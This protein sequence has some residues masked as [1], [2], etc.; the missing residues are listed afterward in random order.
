[1][2]LHYLQHVP[3]EGLGCIA[4]WARDAHLTVTHTR[5]F[6]GESLPQPNEIDFLVVLGG[7]MGVHDVTQYAWL[8]KEKAF[9]ASVLNSSRIPVVGICLGAQLI[10]EALGARVYPAKEKELGW[11]PIQR[12][13]AAG[14]VF[15]EMLPEELEVF[16]WHGDTFDIPR[17]AVHLTRSVA[18]ENQA[19]AVDNRI[20]AL[21]YHLELTSD[22]AA[23]L[24]EHCNDEIVEA[25]FIQTPRQMLATPEKFVATNHLLFE[26]LR[27][28]HSV[29]HER[30]TVAVA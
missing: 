27:A 4:G 11:H 25:P 29:S 22:D 3:F 12:V 13:D 28:L 26:H 16:H 21:Q 19:F 10:A 2:N 8:E 20:L 15:F 30:A 1:M 6:A 23:R 14:S 18:C 9:L 7:P 5:L 24:I 17:G